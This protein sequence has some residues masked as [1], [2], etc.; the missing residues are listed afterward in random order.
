MVKI[1]KTVVWEDCKDVLQRFSEGRMIKPVTM[2]R[3]NNFCSFFLVYPLILHQD[4]MLQL[5]K[6]LMCEPFSDVTNEVLEAEDNALFAKDDASPAQ[7]LN[8][9]LDR[10]NDCAD[11]SWYYLDCQHQAIVRV[12]KLAG[13]THAQIIC[14]GEKKKSVAHLVDID[15]QVTLVPVLFVKD[16]SLYY[17]MADIKK[18][19]HLRDYLP[20][21]T[22]DLLSKKRHNTADLAPVSEFTR[23]GI[24]NGDML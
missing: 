5:K 14:S 15:G 18:T 1:L 20:R 21:V 22:G 23:S 2:A 6:W 16:I 7:V 3:P 19:P 10:L 13:V 8:L 12:K 24:D 4:M 17:L 9:V 11:D